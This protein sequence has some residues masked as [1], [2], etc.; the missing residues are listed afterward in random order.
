MRRRRLWSERLVWRAKLSSPAPLDPHG[1]NS[2]GS[3]FPV[4]GQPD[5]DRDYRH[6][7]MRS[8]KTA[9]QNVARPR[10]DVSQP[11]STGAPV[12][13]S[14]GLSQILPED[15]WELLPPVIE[16]I[17]GIN[18]FTSHYFQL[19]FIPREQ[20]PRRLHQA[21]KEANVF[22]LLSILSISARFTP[23][24]AARYGSGMKASE[25]FM[26]RAAKLACHKLYRPSLEI[27]QAFYLLSIAQQGNG[28]KNSSYVRRCCPGGGT[29]R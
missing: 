5:N 20:F 1:T 19:G 14:L 25:M 6:P 2:I 11:G 26:D 29:R 15:E 23:A 21:P 8:E 9:R 3:I 10:R 28:M 16:V 7:R 27:C 4:R 17:D 12:P 13:R 24:L 18:T 22:L